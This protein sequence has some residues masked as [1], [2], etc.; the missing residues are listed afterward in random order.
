MHYHTLHKHTNE[1]LKGGITVKRVKLSH[2]N[3]VPGSSMNREDLEKNLGMN[4][5]A[6]KAR[7]ALPIEEG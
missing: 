6:L 2:P 7:R 3:I 4:I 1:K 5:R